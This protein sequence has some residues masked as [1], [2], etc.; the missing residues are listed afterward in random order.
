MGASSTIC[1]KNHSLADELLICFC[2]LGHAGLLF[3]CRKLH[4]PSGKTS[5]A[6]GCRVG[7]SDKIACFLQNYSAEGGGT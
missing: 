4:S 6:F 3:V 1:L 2:S 5:H 7:L